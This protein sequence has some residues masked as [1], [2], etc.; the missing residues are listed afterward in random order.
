[1]FLMSIFAAII[2][3]N[4]GLFAADASEVTPY[5][6]QVTMQSVVLAVVW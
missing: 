2:V 4:V 3:D 1:V 6:I 5:H